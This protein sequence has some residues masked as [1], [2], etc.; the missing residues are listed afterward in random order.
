MEVLPFNETIDWDRIESIPVK[1]RYRLIPGLVEEMYDWAINRRDDLYPNSKNKMKEGLGYWNFR[2]L[3]QLNDRVTQALKTGDEEEINF[4][5]K[6]FLAYQDR[7][8]NNYAKYSPS[9]HGKKHPFRNTYERKY[10][11]KKNEEGTETNG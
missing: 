7:M 2:R 10:T 6:V 8:E 11:N 3:L 4:W 9:I 5:R 1:K